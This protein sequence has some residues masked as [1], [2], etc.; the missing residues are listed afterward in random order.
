MTNGQLYEISL[1]FVNTL[2]KGKSGELEYEEF[3]EFFANTEDIY[4]T[5][6][7]IKQLFF[8]FDVSGD[9]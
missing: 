2:D 9:G 7:Q 3:Y 4:L 5:D 6:E 1:D 8:E